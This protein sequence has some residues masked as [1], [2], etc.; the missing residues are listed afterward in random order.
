RLKR[1][2]TSPVYAFFE[3]TPS[4]EYTAG[5]CSHVFK[6]LA[7]GCKQHVWRFLDKDDTKSTSNMTKHIKSCWGESVYLTAQD[8]KTVAMARTTVVQGVLQ[9]GLI[10]SSFERK[11]KGKVTYL[12]RQHTKT[13]TKT[14]MKM[15]CPEYYLPSPSTVSCDVKLVFAKVRQCVVRMLQTYEGELNFAT[16]TWT[17]P[18]HKAFVAISVHLEHEGEPLAM[19]L[20]IVKVSKSHTGLNLTEAFTKVL[21]DFGVSDKVDNV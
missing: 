18:N 1:G 5:R 4:I 13:E 19:L 16:D 2:W 15:G 17:A 14:L 10:M 12:H 6:C 8:T 9:T 21:S 20:D 7:K 3:P 11:G